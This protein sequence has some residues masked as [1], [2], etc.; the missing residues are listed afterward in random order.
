M[1]VSREIWAVQVLKV[2]VVF[3]SVLRDWHTAELNKYLL[4]DIRHNLSLLRG[5][6]LEQLQF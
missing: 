5:S 3:C 4:N 6:N 1:S 2:E